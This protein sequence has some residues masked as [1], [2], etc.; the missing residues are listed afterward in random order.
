MMTETLLV[1]SFEYLVVLLA[2][3][4]SFW[5]L[6][7]SANGMLASLRLHSLRQLTGARGVKAVLPGAHHPAE[8]RSS[9]RTM[10]QTKRV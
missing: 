1:M 5:I 10:R 2:A 7:G 9:K 3:L 4:V 6:S 8:T